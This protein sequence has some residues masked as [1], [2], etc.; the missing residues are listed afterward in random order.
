MRPEPFR[1]SQK[2]LRRVNI[3][4][5][6]IQGEMACARAAVLLRLSVRHIK[7]L[8]KRMREGREA[9]LAHANRGRP[10]PRRLP[11]SV[12]ETIVALARSKYAG[13]NDHHLAETLQEVGGLNLSRATVRRILRQQGLGSPRQRTAPAHRQRRPRVA[14]EGELVQLDG[15]LPASL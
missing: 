3:I 15:R 12:R 2:D 13:F 10:S 9:A 7:R 4:S 5:S 1:S 8:K 11:A 6:R 14:R